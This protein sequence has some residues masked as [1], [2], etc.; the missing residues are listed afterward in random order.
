M[1][2]HKGTLE[3]PADKMQFC[4]R[5]CQENR[6]D[7]DIGKDEKIFDESVAFGNGFVMDI[8]VIGPLSNEPCWTQGVLYRANDAFATEKP[9]YNEVA[10]TEV[11]E[12]LEG[13]FHVEYDGDEYKVEV[14]EVEPE[15]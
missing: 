11:G 9:V 15:P 12:S 10:C 3:V 6:D 5:A 1:T 14:V 8:Q 7:L 4:Q 2:V 13:E